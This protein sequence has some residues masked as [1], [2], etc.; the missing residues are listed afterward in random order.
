ME[1]GSLRRLVG[2]ARGPSGA[3]P[4]RKQSTPGRPCV[5][6]GTETSDTGEE[7]SKPDPGS[8]WEG[9]SERVGA[10]VGDESAE[11]CEVV[12]PLPIP[13]VIRPLRRTFALMFTSGWF[14]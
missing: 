5:E 10:S 13:L 8:S 2:V 14:A 9:H 11:S 6:A 3:G 12:R 1:S 7:T 4:D